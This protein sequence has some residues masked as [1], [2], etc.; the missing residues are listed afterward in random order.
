MSDIYD[1][2][3]KDHKSS[4]FPKFGPPALLQEDEEEIE[5]IINKVL[6]TPAAKSRIKKMIMEM[7]MKAAKDELRKIK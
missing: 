6:K 3:D 5:S 1:L 4:K 7:L 2:Y